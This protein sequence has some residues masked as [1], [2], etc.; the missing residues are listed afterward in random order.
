GG[1]M[2]L[3]GAVQAARAGLSVVLI[4]AGEVGSGASGG[5]LGALFPWMPDRWDAKKQYQFDA[6]VS[7]PHEIAR[8]EEE[9]GLSAGFRRVGRIVPL[10][11]AHLRDIALRHQRDAGVNWHQGGHRFQWHVR[12]R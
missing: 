5:L 11:K 9:T 6:L 12:D 3:W 1:V 4:D 2:G 7:L 8:L 10:P